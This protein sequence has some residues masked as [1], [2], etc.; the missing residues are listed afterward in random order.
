[1]ARKPTRPVKKDA[2]KKYAMARLNHLTTAH[3]VNYG[4]LHPEKKPKRKAK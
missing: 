1:M 4:D 2:Q 3:F